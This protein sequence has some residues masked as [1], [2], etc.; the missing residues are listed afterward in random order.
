[1][2]A[3]HF[4]LGL[5]AGAY[6]LANVVFGSLIMPFGVAVTRSAVDLV[7]S[8]VFVWTLL[9]LFDRRGRFAQTATAFLSLGLLLA[10]FALPLASSLTLMD[11]NP[12]LGPAEMLIL[13]LQIWWFAIAASIVSRA[14]AKPYVVG[15]GLVI[16][17]WLA[18]GQVILLIGPESV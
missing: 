16:A 13:A 9:A 14:I 15:L 10:L 18:I 12:Q 5:V 2:P 7:T 1:M 3:S 17:F 6:L 8:L 4:L 11:E